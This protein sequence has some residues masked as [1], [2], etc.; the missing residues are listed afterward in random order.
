MSGLTDTF[1]RV[2]NNLR[3]SVTDRCNLRCTYC[4]PDGIVPFLPA[5]Q[6]LS[7]PQIA[8]VAEALL[9]LGVTKIRLTG[10]EPLLRPRLPDLIER[11]REL[12]GLQQLALTTNGLRLDRLAKPLRA[13]GLDR[14]NISLD[15][16]DETAFQ[17]VSRRSGL[18]RVLAGIDSALQ[19]GFEDIRLNAISLRGVTEAQVIPLAEF[20]RQHHLTLRFIE[21][22]PLDAERGWSV[23]RVLSGA[24]VREILERHF[25]PLLAIIPDDPHQPAVEYIYPDGSGRIGLI[26]P[27]TEPFC[28][29]CN[30]LRLTADGKLRNCLFSLDEWDLRPILQHRAPAASSREMP[31]EQIQASAF[32]CIDAK[33]AGHLI[34]RPG[35][36]QPQRAMYQIGG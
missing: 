22:M 36:A 4:M 7:F 8:L 32:S 33:L 11:L 27:V 21:Y 13:A 19:A 20:A 28:G 16:L 31:L 15:A 26:N 12:P 6:L 1:G 25:G 5:D 24:A 9:G 18:H 29:D 3:V 17:Q 10:G 34:S 14:L 2:H 30:R 35:F 23:D